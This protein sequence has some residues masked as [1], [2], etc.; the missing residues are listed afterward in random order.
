MTWGQI[1][2]RLWAL[3]YFAIASGIFCAIVAAITVSVI[4]ERYLATARID[5]ETKFETNA[6]Q[7]EV[8]KKQ[9]DVFVRSQAAMAQ[10]VR[11]TGRVVDALRW[12]ES[13]RLAR[14]YQNSSQAGYL[15][16]RSW[17]SE[18][19]ADRIILQFEEGSP[20]F[21]IGYV[22]LSPSEAQTMVSLLRDAYI[23]NSLASERDYAAK[24][25]QRLEN[26]L[27]TLRAK[28]VRL[29]KR[30]EDFGRQNDILLSPQG[31][32]VTELQLRAA[33]AAPFYAN[34]QNTVVNQSPPGPLDKDIE[35][36][37]A[38]IA[39]AS[40]TLGPNHPNLKDLVARRA[41]L[42]KMADNL[43]ASSI[44]MSQPTNEQTEL[45][46]RENEYLEKADAIA[47]AKRYDSE[48]EALEA[49]FTL[50]TEQLRNYALDSTT[51]RAGASA[52]GAAIAHGDVY[53]PRAAFAIAGSGVFGTFFAFT[54]G[55][56]LGLLQVRVLSK[57]DLED[58]GLAVFGSE[59]KG[60][61]RLPKSGRFLIPST[62]ST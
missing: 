14:E 49:R 5:L 41:D 51:Q 55:I 39:R 52:A 32:A 45:R 3:R 60:I 33:A 9:V 10:D 40:V 43:R 4:P 7:Y 2:A 13:Y 21:T 53:Y 36:L 26:R 8:N 48:L 38:Q 61:K 23:E 50:L 30:N 17:L 35:E 46:L 34:S 31:L 57:E 47:T 27:E 24:N 25:Q 20:S 11:V 22:G 37:D 54:I 12:T 56:L 15:D 62:S 59:K 29:E 28:I 19:L 6:E 18:M 16:F 44:P 1:I 58:L 42:S